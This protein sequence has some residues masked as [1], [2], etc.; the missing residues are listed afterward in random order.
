MPTTATWQPYTSAWVNVSSMTSYIISNDYGYYTTSALLGLGDLGMIP[1]QHVV[2]V[3]ALNPLRYS[4][5]TNDRYNYP[6]AASLTI[7]IDVY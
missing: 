5:H 4:G 2:M 1:N 6:W 3:S 7:C